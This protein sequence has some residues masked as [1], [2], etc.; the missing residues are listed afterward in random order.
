MKHVELRHTSEQIN[1]KKFSWNPPL[2]GY[3]GW[4]DIIRKILQ[5]VLIQIQM[6]V[7]K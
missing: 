4:T 7:Y 3:S 1:I 2:W 5:Q 6:Q